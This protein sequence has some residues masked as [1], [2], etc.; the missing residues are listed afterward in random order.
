[1]N[2]RRAEA[3]RDRERSLDVGDPSARSRQDVQ[4]KTFSA[5]FM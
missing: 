2:G 3:V 1:M 4:A 5:T